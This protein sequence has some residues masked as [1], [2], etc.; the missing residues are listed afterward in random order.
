MNIEGFITSACPVEGYDKVSDGAFR[1]GTPFRYPDGSHTDLLVKDSGTLC[2]GIE[3]SDKRQT[4]ALIGPLTLGGAHFRTGAR[5]TGG[6]GQFACG[7][8]TRTGN[9]AAP[10]RSAR[11]VKIKCQERLLP[12]F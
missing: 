2:D 5:L 6:A 10:E 4:M 3:L 7:F 9:F 1:L 8:V 12:P 11:C